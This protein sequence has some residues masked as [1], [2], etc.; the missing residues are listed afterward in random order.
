M[1]RSIIGRWIS[2]GEGRPARTKPKAGFRPVLEVLE[3]RRTPSTFTVNSTG[4][5]GTGS[6]SS[7]DLRYCI[8]Q[9]NSAGGANT[10]QFD[11][12]VFGTPQTITL[13]SLLP[14]ITDNNLTITGPGSNLATVSG[15]KQFQV[16]NITAANASL[17]SL[18][19]ANGSN[20]YGAG[21]NFSGSGTLAIS[22]T[23]L[24]NN[25]AT[26][27]GGGIRVSGSGTL[28]L[29]NSVL[30]GNF[31]A[32]SGGGLYNSAANNSTAILT[33]CTLSGNSTGTG[34]SFGGNNDNG[35]AIKNGSTLTLTDCTLSNNSAYHNGGGLCNIGTATLTNCTLSGNT[36]QTGSGGGTFGGTVTLN[37]TLIAGNTAA[38]DPD[39][40]GT[41]NSGSGFNLIGNGTGMS[42]ITNGTNGN[43]VGT[44]TSPINPLLA[45]LG[46][47]GGLT[48][49]MALLPGSPALDAGSNA[50]DG[51][52]TTDQRGDARI[53]NGTVDIGAFENQAAASFSISAPASTTAGN[54]FSITVSALNSSGQVDPNFTGTITF[55]S[56]DPLAGLPASYTFTS[57]DQGVHTFSVTLKRAGAQ[58]IA[59]IDATTGSA[60]LTVA[61]AAASQLVVSGPSSVAHGTAFSLT[62]T[63]EDPYG[64]VA[65]GYTGTVHFSSSDTTATLP[66]NY[67]FKASDNGTHTFSVTLRKRGTQ[68][69]TVTDTLVGSITGTFTTT[70][71]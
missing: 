28:T 59:A 55:A 46:S 3:D 33:N 30:S 61:P 37:N 21:I 53:V 38:T 8:T 1:T 54:T 63:V 40:A 36:V 65:T 56:T 39:V 42:G 20:S 22:N 66:A 44:S 43:Q 24:A 57:A 64:N 49:T 32:T 50:L 70:V 60:T 58:T 19:V 2:G 7:G 52:V 34:G 29:A 11:S 6:G 25:S 9:A 27:S 71:T 23:L 67:T 16:F 10:I 18:T 4:D 17:S 41:V 69:I 47:Y 15:N 13:T 45:A 5:T 31:A 48:Q 51:G 68:T 12:T 62:V 14:A 26:G 35:G